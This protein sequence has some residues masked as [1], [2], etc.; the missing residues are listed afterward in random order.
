MRLEQAPGIDDLRLL[1]KCR[2]PR[3]CFDF[4]DGGAEGEV[5]L[6]ANRAAFDSLALRPRNLVDISVRD[7]STVVCGSLVEMPVLL[8]P[9]GLTRLFSRHAEVEAARAAGRAGTVYT[10]TSMASMTIEE[11]ARAATG[12]LWFQTYLWRDREVTHSLVRRAR[13]CGYQTLVV[14]VD[15]PLSSK[16]ERDLRNGFTI[17]LRLNARTK[18][19]ALRHPRWVWDYLTGPPITFV[20]LAGPGRSNDAGALGKWINSELSNP[21]HSYD[22]LRRLRDVWPGPIVVKGVLTGEDAELSVEAGAQAISVSNHGGR[23]LD[24]A[25]ATIEALPEI[26][27]AVGRRAEILL[28]GGVRRG[29]DVVKAISL[30]AK[31]VLVGRPYLWGLAAGGEDGAF[32]ALEI[33]RGEID[34]CLALIGRRSLAELEPSIIGRHGLAAA[35]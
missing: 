13:D 24:G 33:L 15:V 2:L 5:T 6:R 22:D 9:S 20:N 25:Q 29:S 11:I 3:V 21:G 19:E 1:A 16:R 26:V 30:G 4:L 10:V 23:Q 35:G 18:L 31:A 34:T 27:A 7:Q 32:R 14:T 17:P 8:A 12:P 28:D